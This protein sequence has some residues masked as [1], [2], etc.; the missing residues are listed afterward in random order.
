MSEPGLEMVYVRHEGLD[1]GTWVPRSS[2]R[3]LGAQ[4]WAEAEPPAP[5]ARD[6]QGNLVAE[7]APADEAPAVSEEAPADAVVADEA[8]TTSKSRA[9]GTNT[10]E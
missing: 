4:G 9:R 10:E 8:P 6:A 7:E 5:P 1:E 2:L 3:Q